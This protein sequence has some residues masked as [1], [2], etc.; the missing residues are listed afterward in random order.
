MGRAKEELA[1]REAAQARKESYLEGKGYNKCSV[2][3]EMFRP[4]EDE[5]I[6]QECWDEKMKD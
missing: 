1:E 5:Y 3:Q 2:C 6:C 4:V